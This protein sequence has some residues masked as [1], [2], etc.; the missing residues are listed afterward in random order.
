MTLTWSL[1][2]L[3]CRHIWYPHPIWPKLREK[4]DIFWACKKKNS[5]GLRKGKTRGT[6]WNYVVWFLFIFIQIEKAKKKER[7]FFFFM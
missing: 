5:I 4:F 6:S 1:S 7:H 2:F 3:L